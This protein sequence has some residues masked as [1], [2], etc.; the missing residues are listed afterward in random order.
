MFLDLFANG[1]QYSKISVVAI[2]G[3]DHWDLPTS[4]TQTSCL[5]SI[6]TWSNQ[7]VRKSHALTSLR[8]RK[9]YKSMYYKFIY[10]YVQYLRPTIRRLI[11]FTFNSYLPAFL[12]RITETERERWDRTFSKRLTVRRFLIQFCRSQR[13]MSLR[14]YDLKTLA[15][16]EA[17]RRFV[18]TATPAVKASRWN[19][20]YFTWPSSISLSREIQ[21]TVM[22]MRI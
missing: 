3:L 16:P 18:L 5:I 1:F 2:V 7:F 11:L 22:T 14:K 21:R 12:V 15:F 17:W 19:F 9:R 20:T 4:L 13:P 8:D 10:M 6:A